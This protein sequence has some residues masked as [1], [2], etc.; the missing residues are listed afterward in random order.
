MSIDEINRIIDALK[1]PLKHNVYVNP[2]D[3]ERLVNGF[4]V[5]NVPKHS[6]VIGTDILP[7]PDAPPGNA[8]FCSPEQW[9]VFKDLKRHPIIHK[10]TS[11][12]DLL[13]F[14]DMLLKIRETDSNM[15]RD[16][17]HLKKL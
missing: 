13:T 10:D 5:S 3:F 8:V 9:Q 16:L 11:V 7:D 6:F 14:A 4:D 1:P 17:G 2:A 15:E 12:E